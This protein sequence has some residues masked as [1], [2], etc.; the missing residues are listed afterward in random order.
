MNPLLVIA[1]VLSLASPAEAA[2]F[3]SVAAPFL[4]APAFQM[5]AAARKGSVRVGGSK[6]GKGSRY[7][8]GYRANQAKA[9]PKPKAKRR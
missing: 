8:G 3:N 5:E 1:A 7:F 6:T 9:P 4:T 2:P